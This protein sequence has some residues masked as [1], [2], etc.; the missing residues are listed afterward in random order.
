M[1]KLRI[2]PRLDV[3]YSSTLLQARGRPAAKRKLQ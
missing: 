3:N 1:A 2:P